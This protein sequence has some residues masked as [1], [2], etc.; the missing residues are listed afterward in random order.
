MLF[1]SVSYCGLQE[2]IRRIVDAGSQ[3]NASCFPPRGTWREVHHGA[4]ARLGQG[5]AH[6]V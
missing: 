4:G 5:K 3:K 6:V 2:T 1:G